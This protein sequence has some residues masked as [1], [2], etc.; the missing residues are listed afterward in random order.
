MAHVHTY[1][2]ILN[3]QITVQTLLILLRLNQLNHLVKIFGQPKNV[4]S[5][6]RSVRRRQSRQN[7]WKHVMLV[8]FVKISGMPKNAK[9]RRKKANVTPRMSKRIARKHVNFAN[10][11]FFGIDIKLSYQ[12]MFDNSFPY[13]IVFFKKSCN[14]VQQ[15]NQLY[16]F[17]RAII[18]KEPAVI[19]NILSLRFED[20]FLLRSSVDVLFDQATSLKRLKGL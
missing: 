20:S 11:T 6:S 17:I 5:K 12:N 3:S 1:V 9:K 8:Q 4:K 14:I 18:T 7:V 13:S 2:F 15:I 10:W 16:I 19:Q